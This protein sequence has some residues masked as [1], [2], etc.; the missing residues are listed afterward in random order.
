MVNPVMLLSS[1]V[2]C[3]DTSNHENNNLGIIMDVSV[4]IVW[5]RTGGVNEN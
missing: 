2:V 1:L 4:C 5:C 3:H